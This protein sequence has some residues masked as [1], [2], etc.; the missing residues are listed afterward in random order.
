MGHI[1]NRSS[2]LKSKS[3]IIFI[4]HEKHNK[5]HWIIQ[6]NLLARIR[7]LARTIKNQDDLIGRRSDLTRR[8]SSN[9]KMSPS[10]VT[11]SNKKLRYLLYHF[12]FSS[13]LF[14]N[15]LLVVSKIMLGDILSVELCSRVKS[16]RQPISS[17]RF[18]AVQTG[19]LTPANKLYIEL[20]NELFYD[21]YFTL[22]TRCF[23]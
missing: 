12:K 6:N 9:D 10:I 8:H 19:L 17:C 23:N 15:L 16:E 4:T 5:A 22:K 2:E 3:N 13:S 11:T 1:Y 18:L 14:V 21:L 20:L 7:S